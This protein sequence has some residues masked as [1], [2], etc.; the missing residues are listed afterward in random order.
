MYAT[1]Y[2]Q[3]SRLRASCVERNHIRYVHS[4]LLSLYSFISLSDYYVETRLKKFK[5]FQYVWN[6]DNCLQ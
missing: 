5:H 3:N 4:V 2:K 6:L 1:K